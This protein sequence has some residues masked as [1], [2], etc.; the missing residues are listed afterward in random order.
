MTTYGWD[1][2]HYDAPGIGTAVS[3][4]IQFITHKAGGDANDAELNTWWNGVKAL[5]SNGTLLLGAYWVLYPGSPSSRAD[6][7]IARLDSQC[8]GWRNMPFILQVDCERWNGDQSTVPSVSE[9]NTFCDRLVTVMPKLNPIGYLPDWVYGDI[10]GF[11]YPLWSSKYVNGTGSFKSLYP[12]DNASQWASYGGK[13]PTILQYTSSAT[14]GGQTTCDA[15]AFRGT[16]K[17][18]TAILA[19]GWGGATKMFPINKGDQGED[20]RWLQYML[21]NLGYTVTA[22]GVFGDQTE[23]AV[24]AHQRDHGQPGTAAYCNG[25]QGTALEIDIAKKFAGKDGAPGAP[26]TPGK[27]GVLTGTLEI[28]GGTMNVVT[29][30]A[31]EPQ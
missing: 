20:V 10:S 31:T 6:S 8:P 25:W 11:R 9:I 1:M 15:N 7:F 18:L 2:S 22:D 19:P 12:G 14:I 16:L 26:G 5:G 17:E 27:D 30:P 4:G 21:L 29:P 28:T 3:E 13:S 24:K 23:A